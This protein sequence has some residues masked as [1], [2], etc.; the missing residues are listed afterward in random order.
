MSRLF[1]LLAGAAALMASPAAAN[2]VFHLDDPFASRGAC[3]AE[4][5]SLSND[6]DF[7][8]DQFPDLFSSEGEVRSFLNRA[9]T[10]EPNSGD[11]QWYINDHR[12]EILGS[13]WFTRRK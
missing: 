4:R 10:C 3:E 5:A 6:D 12:L 13:D 11:G 7:L 9:F 8:I 2:H 1:W